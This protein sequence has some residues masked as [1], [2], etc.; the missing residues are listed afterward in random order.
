MKKFIRKFI[1]KFS[2]YY[3]FRYLT[4]NLLFIVVGVTIL[5]LSDINMIFA[6]I[7][8]PLTIIWFKWIVLP[9]NKII[10]IRT[11]ILKELEVEKLVNEQYIKEFIKEK[12]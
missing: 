4:Y 5:A 1:E 12:K 8:I 11:K 9:N 2:E 3:A 7:L 6:Y 10:E